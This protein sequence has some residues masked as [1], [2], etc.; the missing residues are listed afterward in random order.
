[1]RQDKTGH[2]NNNFCCGLDPTHAHAKM[3]SRSGKP[4]ALINQ[5]LYYLEKY[6]VALLNQVLTQYL[7]ILQFTTSNYLA[8]Q[9]ICMESNPLLLWY[10]INWDHID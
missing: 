8:K 7:Y 4:L 9:F 2:P 3:I 5:P 1:M 6:L 10:F